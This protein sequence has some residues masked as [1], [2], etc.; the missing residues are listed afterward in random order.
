ML[1]NKN[2]LMQEKTEGYC[3]KLLLFGEYT[4]LNGSQ[5]LAVPLQRWTGHWMK[6]ESNQS[7]TE[8][9]LIPYALWLESEKL[10]DRK[11]KEAILSDFQNGWNYESTIPQGYG[12]GSS[13]ALVAAMYDRYFP[14][15]LNLQEAHT[16]MSKM[17]GYFHG[18]SS[19]LDPLISYTGNAIYKD[20]VN[21]YHSV[22]DPGWPEGFKVY[23]LDSGFPRETGPLV[24][25]YK[26]NLLDLTYKEKVER[27]YIPMVE[28]AIHFYLSGANILL[29]ECISVISHFQRQY[30]DDMIP[31]DVKKKWD[32]LIST[33]GVYV[34]L[35]GAG[36]GG[37]FLVI[38]RSQHHKLSIPNLIP[39]A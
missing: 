7:N 15:N 3:A 33:P 37:Y 39:L 35:C 13:G 8:H 12:L 30:F 26:I 2:T 16:T 14:A 9:P 19:G 4:V 11:I 38:D 21:H 27:L 10:I 31:P 25:S 20:E 6:S 18:V 17:E 34:K 23:L 1:I 29:E 24:N 36:G 22:A 32:E 5:A 28:H